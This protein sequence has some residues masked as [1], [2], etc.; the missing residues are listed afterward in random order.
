MN[1]SPTDR[2]VPLGD[3]RYLLSPQDLSGLDAIADLARAGV[4]SLKIEGR[5]KSPEYVAS[6]TR[7]YRAALDRLKPDPAPV[8]ARPQSA[9]RR[10]RPPRSVMTWKWDFRAVC[11]RVGCAG[12]T[13]SGSSMRAFGK[14]RGVFLGTGP[15]RARRARVTS[16]VEAPLNLKAGDGVV[17]DAGQPDQLGGRRPG[18]HGRVQPTEKTRSPSGAARSIFA[19]VQPGD[20]VWK[21]S[22]PELDRRVRQTFAG[23]APRFQRP[24]DIEVHG[25][26]GAPLT[27]V[28]RDGLGHVVQLDSA[29][30]LTVAEQQPLTTERLTEQLGRLGG[31]PFR[32]GAFVNR[33][34]GA[35]ILPVSELNRLR[36]QAGDGVWKPSAPRRNAGEL[37]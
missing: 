11:T 5:L 21:T 34:E 15:A 3:R 29:V 36:R 33:L 25:H 10:K 1:S 26:A 2:S 24:V 7:V 18:V 23:E 31:S 37:Q 17:F 6:I 8:G 4:A 27:L 32:L 14:K 22:D 30:P 16:T 13:T 12:S 28:V 35:V 9:C 20:R 19:R